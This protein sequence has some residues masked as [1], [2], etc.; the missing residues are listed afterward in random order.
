[1][2]CV[3]L[4][5]VYVVPKNFCS[6]EGTFYIE[7]VSNVCIIVQDQEVVLFSISIEV[8]S[9]ILKFYKEGVS[10]ICVFEYVIIQ[11][12]FN[13]LTTGICP[14]NNFYRDNNENVNSNEND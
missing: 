8:S 11:Y 13:V 4:K 5:I 10:P 2:Q 3:P 1:M 6:N 9:G 7:G 12:I 14:L